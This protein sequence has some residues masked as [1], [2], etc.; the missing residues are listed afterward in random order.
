MIRFSKPNSLY[1]LPS[2]IIESSDIDD[3]IIQVDSVELAAVNLIAL[4][5]TPYALV[6]A[7]GTEYALEFLG[8]FLAYD[9]GDT[10][11]TIAT[12]GTL[13]VNYTSGAAA[14]TD[15]ALGGI[16]DQSDDQIRILDKLESSVTPVVNEALMLTAT[17]GLTA[18]TGT[19]HVKVAYRI[20]ATGL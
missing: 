5:A 2:S 9:K 12:A 11:Y 1:D 10:V 6:A 20:H 7:P 19:A 8:A 13:E 15:I 17:E 16:F 18:G 14:S 3:S 4:A